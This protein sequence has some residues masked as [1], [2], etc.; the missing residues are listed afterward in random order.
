M[1]KFKIGLSFLLLVFLCVICQKFILLINY[2]L[3]LILHELAHLF[4][5]IKRGYSLKKFKLNLFGV[6][7]ELT[8]KI[9]DKDAFAINIAGPIFNLFLCV[10]C[11]ALYW[12]IPNSYKILN[13]FCISNLTLAFF[14]LLPIYPLDGGKIFYALL[15]AKKYKKVEKFI[16]FALVLV[17]IVCFVI[18]CF[19]KINWFLLLFAI[20]F[21]TAKT[22]KENELSLFKFSQSKKIEKIILLKATGEETLFDLLKK[23][24]SKKY[25]IFYFNL[26]SPQYIDEDRVIEL[27]TKHPLTSKL[28]HIYNF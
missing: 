18:S 26:N 27:A 16:A 9:E 11:V 1:K 15:G 3:A 12:L 24:Q 4:V 21:A 20:F 14:N 2:I 8:E 28:K 23:I 10:T 19:F 5:A 17:L 13:V 25:T 22:N 6:S 7:I